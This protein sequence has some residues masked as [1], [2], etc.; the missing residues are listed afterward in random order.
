MPQLYCLK[1]K[2]FIVLCFQ[3]CFTHYTAVQINNCLERTYA[4][5]VATMK[6]MHYPCAPGILLSK[7][8]ISITQQYIN[9]CL[10]RTSAI[11]IASMKITDT[12]SYEKKPSSNR[13]FLLSAKMIGTQ[14]SLVP[15]L[16][17]GRPKHQL[18]I[19]TH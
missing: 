17:H 4:I 5:K 10:I 6:F 19:V 18:G 1:G 12:F 3:L 7:G 14:N 8:E 16:L 2:V 9:N 13:Q 11:K 15:K